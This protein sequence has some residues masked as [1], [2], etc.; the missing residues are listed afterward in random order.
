MSTGTR[1][2]FKSDSESPVPT[3]FRVG[4]LAIVLAVTIVPLVIGAFHSFYHPSGSRSDW[5]VSRAIA[6]E[7]VGLT[8]MFWVFRKRG[9]TLRELGV[10]F[11]LTEIGWGPL[12]WLGSYVGI[13]V[14]Y[15]LLGSLYQI[16]TGT[17]LEPI[18][19]RKLVGIRLSLAWLIFLALNP[20]YE[21]FLRAFLIREIEAITDSTSL[22]VLAV[23]LAQASYHIYQGVANTLAIAI[24]FCC[25]GVYY[26]LTRRLTPL[27]VAHLISDLVPLLRLS[28]H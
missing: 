8:V 13:I 16:A 27:I 24:F 22:A 25:F 23:T 15:P 26:A 28:R 9:T 18:D 4:T 10:G 11:R 5:Q 6:F 17:M 21:E 3:L 12:V 14:A 1:F 20:F 7:L 19:A 2:S